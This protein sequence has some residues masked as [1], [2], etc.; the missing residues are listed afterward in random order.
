MS[1]ILSFFLVCLLT[2]SLRFV[3][4]TLL[5]DPNGGTFKFILGLLIWFIH[6]YV[7]M[8]LS[9]LPLLMLANLLL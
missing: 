7:A 4:L 3:A 6:A 2:I 9:G 5:E 1:L 8:T